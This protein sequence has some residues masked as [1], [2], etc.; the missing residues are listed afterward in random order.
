MSDDPSE[1]GLSRRWIIASCEASL[2]RL[3]TDRI[4]LYQMHRPDPDT[5][6]DESLAA[7]DELVQAGKVRLIGTSTFSAMQLDDAYGVALDNAWTKPTS[8]QPPYSLL[9]RGIEDEVLPTCRRHD[10]GCVVWAPLNGGWLTGKYQQ[11]AGGDTDASSRANR[12]AEHFDHRF[13]DI[14]ATKREMVARLLDVAAGAGLS[15][16]QLALGFVLRDPVVASAIIGPRT[17][18]QLD[19]LLAAGHVDLSADVLAAVDAIVAPGAN[20]NPADAG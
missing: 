13:D 15:L 12:V 5:P 11:G 4:D 2:R 3:G 17:P 7:F 6:I 14:A 1:R 19:D 10:I 9:A 16:K 8:E 20:V 18:A